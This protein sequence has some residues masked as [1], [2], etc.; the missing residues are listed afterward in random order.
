VT[1]E[2]FIESGNTEVATGDKGGMLTAVRRGEAAVLARYEG[3]YAATT[4]TVM[5]DRDTFVWDQPPSY[6]RIDDLVAAK[7]VDPHDTARTVHGLVA[8]ALVRELPPG[9]SAL[10]HARAATVMREA[11]LRRDDRPVP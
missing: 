10:M 11:A 7:V 5:G 6:N 4:L 1:K 3:A 9:R 2:A 8:E